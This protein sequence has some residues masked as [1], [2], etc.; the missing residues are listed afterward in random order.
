MNKRD[1]IIEELRKSI[2]VLEAISPFFKGDKKSIKKQEKSIR[3]I[4][5]VVE[6]IKNI[7]DREVNKIVTSSEYYKEFKDMD[8]RLSIVSKDTPIH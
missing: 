8:E 7:D 3:F 5:T 4:E 2:K 1:I 6:H